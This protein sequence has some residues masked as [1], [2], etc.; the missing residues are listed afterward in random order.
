MEYRTRHT[1]TLTPACVG[2]GRNTLLKSGSSTAPVIPVDELLLTFDDIANASLLIGGDATLVADWNTAFGSPVRPFTAVQVND[3]VVNLIGGSDIAVPDELFSSAFNHLVSIVDTLGAITSAGYNSFGD[4]EGIATLILTTATL[5][6]LTTAGNGCFSNCAT[7]NQP[8][9]A[10]TTAGDYCFYKCATL[11]QPFAA[12][13]T[14]GNGC[15]DSC[16]ANINISLPSLTPA[17]TSLGATAGD[18]NVFNGISGNELVTLTVPA[19][20]ETNNGG[21]PDGDIAYLVANNTTVT[22][23]Y[24]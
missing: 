1:P 21:N 14:A 2:V 11:N 6:A 13:T 22:I 9:A 10:L 17:D 5:P 19:Y 24:V 7:L 20:F 4:D 23:T 12:L 18:D 8:F 15:F 16:V 3:N